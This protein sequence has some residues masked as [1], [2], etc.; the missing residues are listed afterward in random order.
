[1]MIKKLV[2]VKGPKGQTQRIS[3]LFYGSSYFSASR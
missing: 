3:R 1:M 2:L